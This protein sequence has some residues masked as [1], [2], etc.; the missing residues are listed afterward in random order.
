V[1]QLLLTFQFV[2]TS[3]LL[4]EMVYVKISLFIDEFLE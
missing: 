1:G 4:K 3:I 2:I